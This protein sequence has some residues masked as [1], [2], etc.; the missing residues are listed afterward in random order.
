MT[1]EQLQDLLQM[2]NGINGDRENFEALKAGILDVKTSAVWSIPDTAFI[3]P[4]ASGGT[5][6]DGNDPFPTHA[7]AIAE[8]ATSFILLPGN[9]TEQFDL[10]SGA[11][12]FS[13]DGVTFV[14]GGITATTDQIG[15]RW[16]GNA[17]FIGNFTSIYFNQ[18]VDLIDVE[19]EFNEI[20]ET[21]TSG[22]FELKAG[23]TNL[24]NVTIKGK[25]F[26]S[27]GG[28]AAGI[29]LRGRLGGTIHI[30]EIYGDYS[31]I[32]A[33]SHDDATIT[34][35]YNKLTLRDGGTPGNS[36]PQ[37]KQALIS[38]SSTASSKIIL[39]GDIYND[40]SS[41]MGS[42]GAT[43]TTWLSG[44]GT[45]IIEGD[46]YT[47]NNRAV[48]NTGGN[49]ILKGRIKSGD[50]AF[51]VAGGKVD[52]IGCTVEQGTSSSVSDSGELWMSGTS[53]KSTTTDHI[54][55]VV[56]NSAE[57]RITDCILEGTS[58][59]CVEHNAGTSTIAFQGSVSS[60]LANST[61]T[62]AC[63]P[64]GFTQQSGLIAPSID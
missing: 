21:G 29:Y 24:S 62:D 26:T 22:R 31:V 37:Y 33:F 48:Y 42:N 4:G 27:V 9:Y 60:N 14:G 35:S 28:N 1:F 2:Y 59:L 20:E 46:I 11:S 58:G 18:S 36:L 63:T 40:V 39:K 57:L 13:Y 56:G 49:I 44:L 19:I 61:L 54:I 43:I 25:R 41:L 55:D 52:V 10:V 12:Y 45:V 53:V 16:L 47:P 8:G 64:S 50:S 6:G 51:Q 5:I 30:D 34:L 17:D 23:I 38:Y 3:E 32:T 7:A 15:T